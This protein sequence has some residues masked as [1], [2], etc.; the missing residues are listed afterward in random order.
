MAVILIGNLRW[1]RQDLGS[2][3]NIDTAIIWNTNS[4]DG[5][6]H[7]DSRFLYMMNEAANVFR[8]YDRKFAAP[9]QLSSDSLTLTPVGKWGD[10]R[11]IYTI[12]GTG[13]FDAIDPAK[14]RSLWS[15]NLPASTYRGLTGD[16]R[17]FWT[18]DHT[19]GNVVQFDKS[20]NIIRTFTAP[21]NRKDL[22]HT[23]RMLVIWRGVASARRVV[24]THDPNTGTEV[25]SWQ[26]AIYSATERADGITGDSRFIYCTEHADT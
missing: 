6:P 5:F 7:V 19:N 12:A 13:R 20:G 17:W 14:G 24:S 25:G 22:H 2:K 21:S 4:R 9:P 1:L 3:R 8:R 16:G 18:I 15:F 11:F 10:G 23:G 26:G